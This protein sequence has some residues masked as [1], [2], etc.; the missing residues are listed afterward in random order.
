MLGFFFAEVNNIGEIGMRVDLYN[1]HDAFIKESKQ[2]SSIDAW[3]QSVGLDRSK[4]ETHP[5]VE[6]IRI[7][8][9]IRNFSTWFNKKDQRVFDH[10]WRQVYEY[11][12]PLSVYHKRKLDQV[13][14][15]VE[16]QRTHMKKKV[17][18]M[19]KKGLSLDQVN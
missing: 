7:L 12:Y 10:I 18:M 11:E 3:C 8:I 17:T 13:V 2:N 1:N 16:Y 15:S 19:S 6:D 9:D 5:Y 4:I 14:T